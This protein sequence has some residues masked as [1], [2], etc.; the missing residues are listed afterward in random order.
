M[1]EAEL[2]DCKYPSEIQAL[3][4]RGYC[5]SC[6]KEIFQG[7]RNS[8][9]RHIY[10]QLTALKSQNERLLKCVE[11]YARRLSW[12]KS[13]KKQFDEISQLDVEHLPAIGGTIPFGGKYARQTLQEIRADLGIKRGEW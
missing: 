1:S 12:N 6:D 3:G 8:V 2:C 7:P 9:E 10:K 5:Q 11:W 13:A 4:A